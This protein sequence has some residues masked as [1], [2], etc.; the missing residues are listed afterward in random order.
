MWPDLIRSGWP[1]AGHS[2]VCMAERQ[3]DLP[4]CRRRRRI[5]AVLAVIG[6]LLVATHWGWVHVAEYVGLTIDEHQRRASD[7]R[8]HRAL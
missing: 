4:I 6:I 2:F 3:S 7:E 8:G 5:D 1:S